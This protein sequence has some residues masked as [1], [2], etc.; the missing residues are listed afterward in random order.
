[1]PAACKTLGMATTQLRVYQ[2]PTDR[3]EQDAWVEWWKGL[4]GARAAYGFEIV[5]A[6]LEIGRAHV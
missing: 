2:L 1:M 5:S 4:A 6:V 3:S